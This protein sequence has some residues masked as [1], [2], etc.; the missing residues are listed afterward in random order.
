LPARWPCRPKPCDRMTLRRTRQQPRQR[1]GRLAWCYAESRCEDSVQ[2]FRGKG[3][4]KKTAWNER[5][6]QRRGCNESVTEAGKRAPKGALREWGSGK[7]L[8]RSLRGG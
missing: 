7:R 2:S 5:A 4:R 6:V 1:G 3:P 8:L